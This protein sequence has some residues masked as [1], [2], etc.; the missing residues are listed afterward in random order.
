MAIKIWTTDIKDIYV[1]TW[2]YKYKYLRWTI[3]ANRNN[4]NVT[5]MSEF[6]ICNSSWTKMSR[7]SWTTITGNI[8]WPN[9]ETVDNI[10]DG[11]V[12]TKYCPNWALPII[13]TITLWSKVDFSVYN[14]YKRYTAND[15]SG[16]DP[17]SWTIEL[18]NDGTNW[19]TASTVSNASITTSRYSL[20]W[21]WTLSAPATW[22]VS[23]VY[24]WTTK[25]RPPADIKIAYFPLENDYVDKSKNNIS[26]TKSWTISFTTLSSWKKVA[27]FQRWTIYSNN[28]FM[29]LLPNGYTVSYWYTVNKNSTYRRNQFYLWW[30]YNT[31][32]CWATTLETWWGLWKTKLYYY[33]D[34]SIWDTSHSGWLN[35][36]IT[37]ENHT[38]VKMYINWNLYTSHSTT[39]SGWFLG[40]WYSAIS[41]DYH[42]WYMSEFIVDGKLRTA[43]EIQDY[44]N[45]TKSNYWIR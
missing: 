19:K 43:Q 10:L 13:I 41:S 45:Q 15:E 32:E 21:T 6:E 30:A 20:A 25:V 42:N 38:S 36:V 33:G 37:V 26:M 11:S 27:N 22:N 44:Y 9:N 28:S 39:Q 18:S 35:A 29:N 12:Y 4:I 14:K 34:N 17:K 7:P 1:W 2:W 8:V 5:Q 24:V 31:L 40:I 3:T 23:A 16:R